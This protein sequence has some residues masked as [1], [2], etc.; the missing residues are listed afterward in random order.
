MAAYGDDTNLQAAQRVRMETCHRRLG[1]ST[2]VKVE[3]L[4]SRVAKRKITF[5]YLMSRNNEGSCY[6]GSPAFK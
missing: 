2:R 4:W 1:T 3:R 6:I 5:E